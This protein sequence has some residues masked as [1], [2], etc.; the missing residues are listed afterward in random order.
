[1]PTVALSTLLAGLTP[2]EQAD[3]KALALERLLNAGQF[4]VGS[5]WV[6]FTR[7]TTWTTNGVTITLSGVSVVS[8]CLAVTLTASDARGPL[9]TPDYAAGE[10][11]LFRNP[12]I[13]RWTR[14]PGTNGETDIGATVED[15]IAVVQGFVYD[16]VIAYALNHGWTHG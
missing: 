1:M 7:F 14:A 12:P 8:G 4:R 16:A 3:R 15:L 11:Y 5:R 2:A 10:A 6:N 9:P 13:R